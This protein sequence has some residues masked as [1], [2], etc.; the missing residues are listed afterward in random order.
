MALIATAR[1]CTGDHAGAD[2]REPDAPR[3]ASYM[4]G[5]QA[6]D[7]K[8]PI[9]QISAPAAQRDSLHQ[10][11][12]KK[13]KVMNNRGNKYRNYTLP[14]M[15]LVLTVVLTLAAVFSSGAAAKSNHDVEASTAR[16]KPTIVLVHGAWA[17]A[18]SWDGVIQRL[19]AKGYTVYAPPNPLLSLQ[20]D[21]A[22][23][24]GFLRTI[25]GPI[26]LVG[27]SYG[28]AVITNAADGVKNVK[29][30]VY[31]DAF[32]PAKGESVLEL[33]NKF[34][35]SVLSTA[36]LSKVFTAA[37]YPG[38]K[39]SAM[40]YV[41]PS[42]FK[43]GFANDLSATEGALA[44]ATQAPISLAALNDKSGA[45]A[46]KHIPSWYVLGTEDGA[47]PPADEMFMAKRIHAHITKVKAGHLSMVSQPGVVTNVI[48][49]A[50]QIV[51]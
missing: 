51:G 16:V 33:D 41:N 34:P 1:P 9:A 15:G 45:P 22:T 10:K 23:I 42:F 12:N 4:P 14:G 7:A 27:H 44:Y 17:N 29:A 20:G 32:A 38:P 48:T 43:K 5:T 13:E 35:G 36:P 49:E 26:V 25:N 11:P 6:P 40:L 3:G 47:I 18:A 21:A 2:I 31:V 50:A 28:G 8:T 37:A 19:E 46:W 39:G 30:L 24:R